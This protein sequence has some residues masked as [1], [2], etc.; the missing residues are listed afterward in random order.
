M[1]PK[2]KVFTQNVGS[3]L[4]EELHALYR[5]VCFAFADSAAEAAPWF[6]VLSE[7]RNIR[8]PRTQIN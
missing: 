8:G 3:A 6:N 7:M 4:Y 5:K 2:Q 1:C